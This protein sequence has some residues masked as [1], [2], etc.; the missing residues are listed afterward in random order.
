MIIFQASSPLEHAASAVSVALAIRKKTAARNLG[1]QGKHPALVVNMG[2][3]SGECDI[4]S[5]KFRG[6][7]GERWTFT[8]SSPSTNLAARL[9]AFARDGQILLSS[10][11]AARVR[12]HFSLRCA[13]PVE[14]KNISHLVEVWEL[15]Y[16][17]N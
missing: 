13:G 12:D 4:G 3:A 7:A 2:V 9:G 14:L 8:A 6:T 15:Q 11:T 10:E 16:A 5:T 1:E 17:I